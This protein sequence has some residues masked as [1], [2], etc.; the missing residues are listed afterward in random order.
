MACKEYVIDI[1]HQFVRTPCIFACSE[2]VF[3]MYRDTQTD[4]RAY[5]IRPQSISTQN[6]QMLNM[7]VK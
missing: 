7:Q 1:P 5:E 2:F 3:C 4:G 6:N